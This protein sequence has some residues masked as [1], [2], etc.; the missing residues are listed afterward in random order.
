[1]DIEKEPLVSVII[2]NYNGLDFL[3][4]CLDSV[5][6]SRYQNFEVLLVDNAST[7]GSVDVIQEKLTVNPKLRIIRNDQN[8]GFAEGNN[9]G[10]NQAKGSM[11]VFL[12]N[13]TEVHA[14]WLTALVTT[15]ISD[16]ST[17]IV[18]C[19][20]SWASS[21]NE[22]RV[23]NVDWYGNAVLVHYRSYLDG[24]HRQPISEGGSRSGT[25]GFETIAAGPVFLIKR[26][27]WDKVG[28]FDSKYFL[29]A[30]DID[31]AW[32]AK[33]LG[34][35]TTLSRGSFVYHRIA[36]TAGKS[37]LDTR[38]YLT[39]R[40]MLRTLLKNYAT[41][42]LLKVIPIFLMIRVSESIALSLVAKNP[43]VMSGLLRAIV[44]NIRSLND[45]W[46]LHQSIQRRRV[47]TDTQVQQVM[48][49]FSAASLFPE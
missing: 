22:M 23:G 10:S 14:D 45:T 12:N 24:G 13:D 30:E 5:L 16:S 44:W 21:P 17:G 7:D 37:G 32:R 34:Y 26:E 3:E 18:L 41:T 29:Y 49:R 11:L 39:Y 8:L 4:N 19:R 28:G 2:L 1:M 15:A 9:A 33:L 6:K 25:S 36:G 43:K 38:R 20:V 40:N 47:V 42:T 31:L 35:K 46:V 27:V 48:S